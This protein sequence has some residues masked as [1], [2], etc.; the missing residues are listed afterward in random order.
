MLERRRKADGLV[1]GEVLRQR[2]Y[3]RNVFAAKQSKSAR[4]VLLRENMRCNCSHCQF[5]PTQPLNC[6]ERQLQQNILTSR[7]KY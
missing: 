2:L 5:F 4:S 3:M 7:E 6:T 1:G